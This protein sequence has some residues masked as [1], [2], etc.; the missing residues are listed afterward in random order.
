MPR[1]IIKKDSRGMLNAVSVRTEKARPIPTGPSL[2][3][4][5]PVPTNVPAP[6]AAHPCECGF[7]AASAAGLAAHKRTRHPEA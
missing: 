1:K 4:D 3:E 7:V 2:R 6:Q 5:P